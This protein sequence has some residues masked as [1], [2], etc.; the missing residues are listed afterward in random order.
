M[1]NMVLARLP[2]QLPLFRLSRMLG[3]AE[4]AKEPLG[5]SGRLVAGLLRRESADD[6]LRK[7]RKRRTEEA[8]LPAELSVLL[9]VGLSMF[10]SLGESCL[11]LLVLAVATLTLRPR[12]SPLAPLTSSFP[13]FGLAFP[14][15]S[16]GLSWGEVG[17]ED[18]GPPPGVG[19]RPG[20]E[21]GDSGG[22]GIS[23]P[24]VREKR[25]GLMSRG[26]K[27][28]G[29]ELAGAGDMACNTLGPR[30]RLWGAGEAGRGWY[31]AVARG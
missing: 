15:G 31:R 30:V 7:P 28:A 1:P 22:A 27:A 19:G 5:L 16:S 12:K 20:V 9:T 2:N 26:A 14:M 17:C 24:A 25:I 10:L 4:G 21:G 11:E 6:A 8:R 13:I 3:R 23:V 29:F 18:S